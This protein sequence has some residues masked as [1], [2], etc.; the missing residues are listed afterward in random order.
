M[1]SARIAKP[2][3]PRL[4]TSGRPDRHQQKRPGR[5]RTDLSFVYLS[6]P[7]HPWSKPVDEALRAALFPALISN[8]DGPYV[9]AQSGD[10]KAVSHLPVREGC[11]AVPWISPRSSQPQLLDRRLPPS[12]SLSYSPGSA[13]AGHEFF[14]R[15]RPAILPRHARRRRP[16][17]AR[18]PPRHRRVRP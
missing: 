14:Q 6:L 8:A 7:V 2:G 15:R 1:S 11:A 16:D 10:I 12:P 17:D 4:R 5:N 3:S 9:V 18:R 13:R